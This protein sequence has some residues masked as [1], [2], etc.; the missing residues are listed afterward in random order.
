M[1][2]N[3]GIDKI[4]V[5]VPKV[6][7]LDELEPILVR[8]NV[9]SYGYGYWNGWEA[10]LDGRQIFAF[11]SNLHQKTIY[12]FNLTQ[13]TSLE[14][15]LRFNDRVLGSAVK[16]AK[17][18]RLTL[19]TEF[20]L[21]FESLIASL[22]CHR[23]HNRKGIESWEK[24]GVKSTGGGKT[25]RAGSK[26]SVVVQV[27]Q[28]DK[29]HGGAPRTRVSVEFETV[30]K[31]KIPIDHPVELARYLTGTPF[32]SDVEYAK[33][34]FAPLLRE[35]NPEIIERFDEVRHIE[36]I[37]GAV[38]ELRATVQNFDR[39]YL[40]TGLISI[41]TTDRLDSQFRNDIWSFI[42]AAPDKAED[43]FYNGNFVRVAKKK[44]ER[45]STYSGPRV[46]TERELIRTI[47]SL[48]RM[49]V[50][51]ARR[52]VEH[53]KELRVL[54]E[55]SDEQNSLVGRAEAVRRRIGW[56]VRSSPYSETDFEE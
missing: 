54:K 5:S 27:Y 45:K 10:D 33:V 23:K 37:S 56:F 43:D 25:F 39:R 13:W 21:D 29:V 24:R 31:D 26:K 6:L 30:C 2:R 35:S 4:Y 41:S 9:K 47:R 38:S 32:R 46:R 51:T 8:R 36:S 42:E 1:T 48:Q 20:D 34:E 15:F 40:T 28:A 55:A 44:V 16:D 19:F 3:S 52:L 49:L 12:Q 14:G 18:D 22:V 11:I 53:L 17:V 50:G 7:N